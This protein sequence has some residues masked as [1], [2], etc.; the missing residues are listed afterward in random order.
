MRRT[1][2]QASLH[3]MRPMSI[4]PAAM[5]RPPVRA[6][7]PSRRRRWPPVRRGDLSLVPANPSGAT[8]L[9]GL[10]ERSRVSPAGAQARTQGRGH[11]RGDAASFI[12]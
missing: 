12:F 1:A 9:G 11:C 2:T 10:G 5:G 4:D 6:S 8:A 3:Q 7:R